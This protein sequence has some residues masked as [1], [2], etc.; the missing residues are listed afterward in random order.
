MRKDSHEK[1][2][3]P[4]E[5][6]CCTQ[7]YS[8]SKSISRA[9]PPGVSYIWSMQM[10]WS[11]MHEGG[12]G[13]RGVLNLNHADL[14]YRS[15]HEVPPP[16]MDLHDPVIRNN[17]QSSFHHAGLE[18]PVWQAFVICP[19]DVPVLSLCLHIPARLEWSLPSLTVRDNAGI[20][21]VWC[22]L[23]SRFWQ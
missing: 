9:M 21:W 7:E 3:F 19:W 15:K 1:L 13:G 14:F 17:G 2:I 22:C 5:R 10:P 20:Y 11:I 23:R 4:C 12:G 8:G 16:L 18:G 6:L